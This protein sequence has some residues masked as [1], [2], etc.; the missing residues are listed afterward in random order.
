MKITELQ[1]QT[2]CLKQQQEF[3]TEV[4]DLPLVT[5]SNERFELKVG[6]SKLIFENSK[7]QSSQTYHFAFNVPEHQFSQAKAWLSSR[8]PLLSGQ[9]GMDEFLFEKWNAD[10]CY[11]H[12]PAGNICEL[13]ARHNLPSKSKTAFSSKNILNISEIGIAVED[14]K[15]I[16]KSFKKDL[17]SPTYLD[18]ESDFFTAIGDENGLLIFVK[19]ERTWFPDRR[20]ESTAG[21]LNIVL[22]NEQGVKF[23]ISGPPYAVT[24]K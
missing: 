6:S 11:F 2:N 20:L 12:D 4:L 7:D 3:Y 21:P 9:N 10:A 19:L 13:I 15:K 17:D 18:E 16:A 24:K 14:V 8:V 22:A 5:K 1:L 23:Q